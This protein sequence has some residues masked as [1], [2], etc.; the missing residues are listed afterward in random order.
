MLKRLFKDTKGSPSIETVAIIAFV[1][2]AIFLNLGN[3]G[4]AIG[5]VFDKVNT[6]LTEKIK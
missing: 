1:A 2:L 6:S 4:S 3:M 5:G